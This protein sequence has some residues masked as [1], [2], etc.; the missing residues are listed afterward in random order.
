[1]RKTGLPL[2]LP[3]DEVNDWW[4]SVNIDIDGELFFFTGLLYQLTPYIESSVKILE[5]IEKSKTKHLLPLLSVVPASFI[6]IALSPKNKELYSEIVRR[7]YRLLKISGVSLKYDPSLDFYSGIILY[8]LGEEGLFAEHA[9]FVVEKL[10]ESGVEKVVTIDPHTAY[11]LKKLYPKFAGRTFK[12]AIYLEL[13]ENLKGSL[14]EKVAL[15]DPC[16]YA[17]YLD[18]CESIRKLLKNSGVR[19]IPVRNSGEMTSC[20]GGTIESLSARL[21]KEIAKIRVEELGG[22]KIVTACPICLSNLRRAGGNVVDLC[23]LIFQEDS[24]KSRNRI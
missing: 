1:M 5:K 19:V 6:R 20:C 23:S 8:D 9:N 10:E 22:G 7:I 14:N 18:A 4:R 16:Y 12:V 21:S 17:R 2:K 24:L 3:K 13:L 11:A 15:H